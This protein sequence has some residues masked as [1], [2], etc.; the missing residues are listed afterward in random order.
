M[1]GSKLKSKRLLPFMGIGTAAYSLA[2]ILSSV[3]KGALNP[4]WLET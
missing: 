1:H 4:A 2:E 3:W